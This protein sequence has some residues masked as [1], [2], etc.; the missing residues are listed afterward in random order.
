MIID[1]LVDVLNDHV[2][3]ESIVIGEIVLWTS[4]QTTPDT[5]VTFADNG[6]LGVSSVVFVVVVVVFIFETGFS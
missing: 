6:F 2:L 5:E 3:T 4:L 1:Q